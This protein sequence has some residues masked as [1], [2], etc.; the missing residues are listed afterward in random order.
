[1]NPTWTALGLPWWEVDGYFFLV[2]LG[3]MRLNPLGTSP[4]GLLHQPRIIDDNDDEDG[5]VV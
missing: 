1:M 3:G 2:F 5:A 4:V